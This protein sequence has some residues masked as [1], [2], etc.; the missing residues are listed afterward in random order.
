M[1]ATSRRQQQPKAPQPRS[2]QPV[3]VPLVPPAHIIR[4][5]AGLGLPVGRNLVEAIGG[6]LLGA[7]VTGVLIS[8]TGPNRWVP[9]LATGML[10]AL[11]TMTSPIGTFI[12]EASMGML[13][14]SV[15]WMF[16]DLTRGP[17]TM[18]SAAFWQAQGVGP[19]QLAPFWDQGAAGAPAAAPTAA[20]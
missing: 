10:G 17:S 19:G 16:F 20:A 6:A 13:G 14:A 11:G 7:A 8:F 5:Q 4:Q 12:S 1:A 2:P 18:A 9:A 3:S 15:G